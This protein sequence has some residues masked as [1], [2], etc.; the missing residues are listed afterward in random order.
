MVSTN[1]IRRKKCGIEVRDKMRLV[2]HADSEGEAL[3][4]T[5]GQGTPEQAWHGSQGECFFHNYEIR[6]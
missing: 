6:R 3:S 4:L 2:T 1:N 5:G